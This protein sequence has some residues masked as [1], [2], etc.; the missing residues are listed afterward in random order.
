M[1][2][3][4]TSKL[5][6]G[7]GV[8][9]M[10]VSC[11]TEPCPSCSDA[12]RDRKVQCFAVEPQ[13]LNRRCECGAL[14]TIR[15]EAE[16]R[17]AEQQHCPGGRFRHSR[18][19][20]QGRHKS[21]LTRSKRREDYASAREEKGVQT[22][23]DTSARERR[24]KQTVRS[25]RIDIQIQVTAALDHYV[26]TGVSRVNVL[27]KAGQMDAGIGVNDNGDI[28]AAHFTGCNVNCEVARDSRQAEGRTHELIGYGKSI[29][30]VRPGTCETR[31][32][33][34][35]A[36]EGRDSSSQLLYFPHCRIP[37]FGP[38]IVRSS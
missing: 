35:Y 6:V 33:R 3:P 11:R 38:F 21:Q 7:S 30:D 1:A 34:S 17:E 27:T 16:A 31:D 23:Y 18:Y 19:G 2:W 28:G 13:Y 20:V 29:Y 15:H 24:R 10:A 36:Q 12:T 9:E 4:K 25:I 26:Y 32:Q 5:V 22:G 8:D 14:P 37:T